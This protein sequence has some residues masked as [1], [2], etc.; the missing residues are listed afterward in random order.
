MGSWIRMQDGQVA[1]RGQVLPIGLESRH[2]P[3]TT[4]ST[5]MPEGN[6]TATQWRMP[7]TR[8]W[9][10]LRL[11]PATLPTGL[12]SKNVFGQTRV[13]FI[14]IQDNSIQLH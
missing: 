7:V 2:R 3:D 8:Y 4:P 5:G 6:T 11:S 13:K 1:E 9:G 12:F 10:C 14:Q